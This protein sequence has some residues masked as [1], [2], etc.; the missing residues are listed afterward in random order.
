[1]G[2]DSGP[3]E[4]E[5]KINTAHFL[6]EVEH[7]PGG[8]PTLAMQTVQAALDIPLPYYIRLN[9]TAFEKLIDMIGGID[10]NVAETIDDPDY[11][12]AGFGYDPFHID[13]GWQHMDG[14]TALKVRAHPRHGRQR[15]RSR[16]AP[17]ASD[18]DGAR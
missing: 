13:A 16:Q 15:S 14:R 9:F 7:V 12:D 18:P 10:L 8:G 1:M 2:E 4:R 11:P 5:G 3:G 17:A 6:G